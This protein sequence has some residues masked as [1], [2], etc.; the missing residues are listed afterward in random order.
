MLG[1]LEFAQISQGGDFAAE[2]VSGDL[3]VYLVQ[4]DRF[5]GHLLSW[6]SIHAAQIDIA[7]A[8]FPKHCFIED[9]VDFVEMSRLAVHVLSN[10]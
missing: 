9:W 1:V 2:E 10:N 8:S 5:D 7:R 4:V 6:V 3:V